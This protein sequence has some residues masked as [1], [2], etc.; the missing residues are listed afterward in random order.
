VTASSLPHRMAA[1][2]VRVARGKRG[3]KGDDVATAQ[4]D[5]EM[6]Y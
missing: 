2:V 3:R 1:A 6:K 5:P 4:S